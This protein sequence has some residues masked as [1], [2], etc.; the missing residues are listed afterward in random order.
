[1]ARSKIDY[2][3]DLG[4]T[5]SSIARMEDGTPTIIKSNFLTDTTPSCIS[6][7]KRKQVLVGVK[8]RNAMIASKRRATKT[9]KVDD[10]NFIEFKRKMGSDETVTSNFMGKSFSPEEL[11]AEVLK[12]LKSYVT[13]ENVTSAVVTVPA[14]FTANQTDATMRA[15]KLAGLEKCALL[16]EPIAASMAYGLKA[17]N[18]DG[19]WIVFDLGGGTFDVA[20]LRVEDGILKVFDT[21]GDNFLGGKNLDYA[22]TDELIIPYLKENYSINGILADETKRLILREAMKTYA[23]NAKIELSFKDSVS[24]E[25][26]VD[27]LGNDGNGEEMEMFM[28]IDRSMTDEIVRPY[29]QK[30]IDITKKLLER[31][32]ISIDK[33]T[34]LILVGGPT[35]TPLLRQMLV[36]QITPNVDTSI[37]PMTA[38]AV[39]AALYA[40]TLDN[41]EPRKIEIGTIPLTL[42]YKSTSVEESELVTVKINSK[43]LNGQVSQDLLFEITR[44]DKSWSSGKLHLTEQGEIADC[45][46]NE[47]KSNGFSIRVFDGVGNTYKCFPNSFSIIQGFDIG[48]AILPYSIGMEVWNSNKGVAVFTPIKGLEKSQDLPATGVIDNL[49]TTSDIR[50]GNEYDLLKIPLYEGDYG[51]DEGDL[52]AA[53]YEYIYEARMT[54]KNIPALLPAGSDVEV[55]VKVDTSRQISLSVYI[56]LL[57]FTQ[58][59]NVPRDTKQKT[60][61][62]SYL[63]QEIS[64]ANS[65]VNN[66]SYDGADTT[67][68][69]KGLEE[70]SQ[71]LNHGD[72]RKQVLQHLKEQLRAI[73]QLQKGGEWERTERKLKAK[74]AMLKEDNRKYGN[75]ETGSLVNEYQRQAD[76]VISSK[77]VAEAKILLDKI[78]DLDMQLARVEYYT[79]WVSQWSRDFDKIKWKDRSRARDLVNRGMDIITTVPDAERLHPI[80]AALIN[81]MPTSDI[82]SGAEGLLEK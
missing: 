38:V 59:I 68:I 58:E 77:S 48:N 10:E 37:D 39:G 60:V 67:S 24:I 5:N 1:M 43:E 17:D 50:P 30:A 57:D 2:G 44:S 14:K 74:M 82:P 42:K 34:S 53:Y 35:Y 29:F 23:E 33:I 80:V 15:A 61:S 26:L 73:A 66:L 13:D 56:P 79:V 16:Q 62:E 78:F 11:S 31:N 76:S 6:I 27:E 8:A 75:S 28:D 41:D 32:N 81:L 4:T 21:E 47:G 22:I 54:G 45:L 69:R 51:A 55:T 49:K 3:I 36:E 20:L 7:T 63:K 12:T 70:V 9:W 19:Y 25:T 40:S 65:Q 72:E 71:E 18:K 52:P 46:L 64:K